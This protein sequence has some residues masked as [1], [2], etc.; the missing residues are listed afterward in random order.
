MEALAS[1]LAGLYKLAGVALVSE[2]IEAVLPEARSY[3]LTACG[4]IY[5]PGADFSKETVVDL[6]QPVLPE[7][8]LYSNL[9]VTWDDWVAAWSRDQAGD[10]T[11]L[12][13]LKEVRLLP[14]G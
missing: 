3:R 1:G 10:A 9:P 2:Q 13:I 12:P 6:C 11:A 14:E 8:L 5:W 7:R 4:L